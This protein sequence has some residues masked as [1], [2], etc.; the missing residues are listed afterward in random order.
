ME[1]DDQN[2]EEPDDSES[3]GVR[4]RQQLLRDRKEALA[5]ARPHSLGAL[6]RSKLCGWASP[7]GLPY[8]PLQGEKDFVALRERMVQEGTRFVP[9]DSEESVKILRPIT[10]LKPDKPVAGELG[11]KQFADFHLITKSPKA[12]I[13]IHFI[14]TFGEPKLYISTNGLYSNGVPYI[15]RNVGSNNDCIMITPQNKHYVVGDYWL[16]VLSKSGPCK[17]ILKATITIRRKLTGDVKLEKKQ[18]ALKALM[19]SALKA[20]INRVNSCKAGADYMSFVKNKRAGS[21]GPLHLRMAP[22]PAYEEV[23]S[24]ATVTLP[25][26]GETSEEEEDPTHDVHMSREPQSLLQA[27]Q[28][29]PEGAAEA[30]TA[31]TP[32]ANSAKDKAPQDPK[33]EKGGAQ[34]DKADKGKHK[35]RK[36][37]EVVEE[38]LQ[39][40]LQRIY[41]QLDGSGAK[42]KLETDEKKEKK[43][44]IPGLEKPKAG[45]K[46]KTADEGTPLPQLLASMNL[47]PVLMDA[48]QS[49]EETRE[50][51]FAA[52][53]APTVENAQTLFDAICLE[54]IMPRPFT[55]DFSFYNKV[56]GALFTHLKGRVSVIRR[57][58]LDGCTSFSGSALP[59]LLAAMPDLRS[60]SLSNCSQ[61]SDK[62]IVET[63][64]YLEEARRLC[65][66]GT[67]VCD[68]TTGALA[69]SCPKLHTLQLGST[70]LT[71]SGLWALAGDTGL[72]S[73][74]ELSL[75]HCQGISD[76]GIMALAGLAELA[77]LDVSVC[78][79]VS[80]PA[81]V[82]VCGS[83]KRLVA[84]RIP[85]CAQITDRGIRRLAKT[86]PMLQQ[87]EL[88][89][90]NEL[91]SVGVDSLSRSCPGLQS[92]CLARCINLN[93]E[94]VMRLAMRCQHLT[95]LS[96]SH[97]SRVT[98]DCL[99]LIVENLRNL[100]TLCVSGCH[101]VTTDS[102]AHVLVKCEQLT[103]LE[104]VGCGMDAVDR[105]A[106]LQ[107][108]A[109]HNVELL[110]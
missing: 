87:L 33:Q 35:K 17:F 54:R 28:N 7:L 23:I 16:S 13:Y 68:L 62:D 60:L 107:I 99:E 86:K 6:D 81:L 93:E 56:T 51:K 40:S 45:R 14:P 1:V 49:M 110:S 58:V 89:S 73:L 57:L 82:L 92:L 63:L 53:V 4:L 95:W 77:S 85:L 91:T 9:Q 83:L 104:C 21:A 55:L 27:A 72:T 24:A 48:L 47:P 103:L 30:V 5:V 32:G 42:P 97:C 100:K 31:A 94:C 15:W 88:F 109:E 75:A 59:P 18:V 10:E 12:I 101:Q 90:C 98:D 84:L 22:L 79:R 26:T 19:G 78:R 50:S 43:K 61:L 102:I 105:L 64:P 46:V 25:E 8:K 29:E 39:K 65:L 106:L 2:I 74:N 67:G 11:D 38:S 69:R 20:S 36:D 70:E 41:K 71:D 80:L 76:K 108:A 34:A 96:L 3:A 66:V 52:R 37:K 44:L